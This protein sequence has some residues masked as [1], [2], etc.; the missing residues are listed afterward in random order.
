MFID[1]TGC[2]SCDF[3]ITGADNYVLSNDATYI[4]V[5]AVFGCVL[6]VHTEMKDVLE[7]FY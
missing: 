6:C 4:A 1:F 7:L 5:I 2:I 3:V